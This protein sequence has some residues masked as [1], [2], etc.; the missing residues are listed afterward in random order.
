MLRGERWWQ[1]HRVHLYQ[2]LA[3]RWEGH[4]P[5]TLLYAGWT[6]ACTLAMIL[7]LDASVVTQGVSTLVA[8]I[9]G[10]IAWWWLGSGTRGPQ[11]S[12]LQ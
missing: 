4:L 7:L 10:A 5:V 1:P 3:Q 2:R 12:A 9:L 6:V 11:G 8:Y